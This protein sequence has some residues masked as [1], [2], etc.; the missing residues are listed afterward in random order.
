MPRLK[1]SNSTWE[2]TM[3]ETPRLRSRQLTRSSLLPALALSLCMS[4]PAKAYR[5]DLA[6]GDVQLNFDT[7]LS[8]GVQLRTEDPNPR[9]FGRDNGGNVP[10]Q[11]PLGELLH[12]PGGGAAANPDFNF[13]NGDN[14]DLNYRSGDL[15]S[16]ALKGTHELG[17]KWGEG[18]S[19]LGRAT[20]LYDGV[21]ADTRFTKLSSSAKDIA[22]LNFTPLDLWVA[23][24]FNL[25]DRPARVKVGNQVVSWGED[26]FIIGG[27]NSV[28]ALD[29][30][31]F[32][33]PG[34][35][36]KEVF[37]PAPMIYLNAAITDTLNFEAYYQIL[38]N[39]FRFDPV[40][41]FFSGA[42]VVG[43]GQQP[44]FAPT[45]FGLCIPVLCGD[46]TPRI[47][48]P[49]LPGGNIVPI[50]R[51][52][53][54]PNKGGQY[55]FALRYKP[56][57]IESEFA[58]YYIRYHDKL[59]FT[60]F[61]FDPR[62]TPLINPASQ[63][64][65]LGLT[66]FNE[67]GEDKDLFGLSMNTKVGPVAVGAELS[68]R[69]RDSVAIDP[70]VPTPQNLATAFAFPFAGLA[71]GT[72]AMSYGVLDGVSCALGLGDAVTP[73]EGKQHDPTTCRTTVRGFV[74]E[75]K[76][77]AHLTGFY[78]IEVNS[79][80]GRAMRALGA[81]EGYVLAE[82]A[83]THYPNLDQKNIPYLIFPSYAVPDDTSAGYVFEIG[84]T[85]PHAIF[86]LNLTP[87][88]DFAHDFSGTSPN[89]L[90]FVEGRKSFFVGLNFDMDSVV[91]GQIGYGAFFGGGLTNIITDRDFFSASISYAF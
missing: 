72:K 15:T 87:Q 11:G 85:Y 49:A 24:D 91:R 8:F 42:D 34:T 16:A 14:G 28:N 36:L 37:R 50:E 59:P 89:T 73:G 45:S 27:I 21:V 81:A 69:P 4:A 25:F 63:A 6:N 20:W 5:W 71:S 19:A 23:K 64:N 31:R 54:T 56:E 76:W 51:T 61:V 67:F 78:F 46:G 55:G 53:K 57:Q 18:W 83:I 58:F 66:Y 3:L 17:V 7:T 48:Q 47:G 86:G 77:Q 80:F 40:G 10:T 62:Q 41:T 29:L 84:L 68:Y 1:N 32:H 43:K 33:T 74:E 70:T 44:A 82:M 2:H 30:R 90:P 35:Q 12:G 65:L 75:Q 79:I 9:N 26:I 39:S 88:I 22:E 60:S 38:W 13:L 52:D